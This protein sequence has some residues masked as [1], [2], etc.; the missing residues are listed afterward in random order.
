MKADSAQ[1]V[2]PCQLFRPSSQRVE[3]K[4]FSWYSR[5]LSEVVCLEHGSDS[6]Q[7]KSSI[8]YVVKKSR[9]DFSEKT[10]LQVAKRAGWLCSCPTCRA[11]TVGAT[12]DGR[13]E[14]NIGTAAH[15]CAA[16]SGG[17]RYDANM[18][19]EERGSANNG[20]WLCRDHGKA[21]DS[22]VNEFTTER[23]RE[24][25]RQAEEDSWRRVLWNQTLP[26]PPAAQKGGLNERFRRAVE[27]DLAV[28]R[29][30]TKWPRTS[31][32]LT[33]KV[34]GY[35][36]TATTKG[37][38]RA[39]GALDDLILVAPPGMGKTTTIFQIAEGVL[40]SE[41]GMPVVVPLGD[42]ATQ[43]I[44]I[45]ESI[46]KRPAF[47]DLSEADFRAIAAEPGVV[48]LLDGWNEL[49]ATARERARVQMETLKAELPELGLV[50]STRKQV[51]DVPFPGKLV[52]LMPL[53][54]E[55]QMEIAKA[56]RGE[57]G[58]K[59]VD[60]AWRTP[61]I[62]EL[63]T[64]PLYLTALLTLSDGAPFPTTKEEVL[65]RFVEAHEKDA[66]RAEVLNAEV[67]G[68]QQDFL[69]GL[70]TFATQTANTSITD[71]NARHSITE[72][73]RLLFANGQI[74]TKP[75]PNTVLETLVNSHVL[76][77]AGDTPGVSFQHQQFQEWYASHMVERRM[78]TD[79]FDTALREK[80]KAEIFNLPAWEE[81]ILFAVER[82]A[83]G[84]AP[85]KT[86][87]EKAILAAF[88]VDPMLAAE[89]I[90]HATDDVW[91]SIAMTIQKRLN[92]WH[93]PGKSDRALRFMM[94]SGRPEFFDR[95]WPLI[96]HENQQISLKALR[97]CRRFRPSLLGPEAAMR[98]KALP[99]RPRIVLLHEIASRSGMD[100]LDLATAIAK[101]D[102]NPEVQA[103]V[104]DALAFR[105][106]DRHVEAVL[107]T[108]KA[109]TFDLVVQKNLIEGVSD[110]SVK[111]GLDDA[112]ERQAKNGVS[113][114]D[115]LHAVV[116]GKGGADLSA[117]LTAII[118]EIEEVKRG[119]EQLIYEVRNRYP[120]AV[121]EGVL[122]RVRAGRT[123]FYGADDILA[124]AGFSLEE[125]ALVQLALAETPR[126]DDRA[127][128]AAS[129]LGSKAAGRILDTLADVATRL[130]KADGKYDRAVS[131]RY[132][133]LKARVA[134][135]PGA[136]LITAIQARSAQADN[137]QMA[138]LAEL[139]SRHPNDETDRCR[140]FDAEALVAIRALIEDWGNRMLAS[141]NAKRSELLSIATLASCAP[142]VS[143]LPL[144]KRL[145]DDNLRRYRAFREEAAAAGW[146][147]GNAVNEATWP[148]THEYK[149]AFLAIDA[150]ETASLMRE[151]LADPHFGELAAGVLA[152]QWKAAN[153]PP[154]NKRLLGGV[155]FSRVR[156][157]R[158]AVAANPTATS[159]EAEAMFAAIE[160]LIADGATDDQKK[161]AAALG[162]VAVRLPHGQR[163]AM[164]E[165]L[166]ALTPRRGRAT[167][168]LNLIL[169]GA[170]I[171]S[172]L[173]A[174]GI[175]ETFEAAKKEPWIL[176]QSDGYE[177]RDWLRLLPFTNR[178]ANALKIVHGMPDA[179]RE[180]RF[181]EG[182][183][184]GFVETPSEAAEDVLFKLG[185][186]DPR[187]Y[188]NY[189]WRDAALKLGTM[190]AACRLVDLTA[191]GAFVGQSF[192]GRLWSR[193]LGT[194][195]AEFPEV[196]WHVY[197]LLK[198]GVASQ[199]L[200]LLA[201]A[202][203]ES[204]DSEGLLLLV[205]IENKQERS[206]LGWR[207][208]EN[209]VTEHVPVENWSG[210][211]NVVPVPAPELRQ[212]LFAMMTDGGLTDAA[213]RCLNA[214]GAIRD[215]YGVP[216]S[217]PRHPDL[218]S[219]KSWPIMT[220]D[221]DATVYG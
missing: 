206:L 63:V 114:Y 110:E 203:A 149:R 113:A 82:T 135:I 119:E 94:N 212:K 185:E 25:K 50:V 128:A 181:L 34:E 186:E 188:Q 11:L 198:G 163:E 180:P 3:D 124:S 173:V 64:I 26:E 77:R 152:S 9:D 162:I 121:A 170:E 36:E 136:S 148:M 29:N 86:A 53:N 166:V 189:G 39:V 200:E 221:P 138:R 107:R 133:L 59:I 150:P 60:Q 5:L 102:H 145:L 99:P 140:P 125:E 187:F 191:N 165:K 108:A 216:L 158:A 48:L 117:E 24:W 51:L 72:T 58:A 139:L 76:M 164:I 87:C 204:P 27:A 93:L 127:E 81:A 67:K 141:G 6:H 115:R 205:D 43:D 161:L 183:V 144:L 7:K 32:A 91:A 74:T 192:D 199:P 184:R 46:L 195:I 47:R 129:V 131:D 12:A 197:G 168:L 10:K 201:H 142:D 78:M 89:M 190:S 22:D 219:R 84:G 137:E 83:R 178:P 95:I 13:S 2:C 109:E 154:P 175:A 220:L 14:I 210:A 194:L 151:Y 21:V 112:R 44:P 4:L 28:F 182:M 8:R 213:A 218:A 105:R 49:N 35:G 85:G 38:A 54:D 45:L 111:N 202:I 18:T 157:K 134:H 160:P 123:L 90:Y 73:G 40:A 116:Y 62:R 208:I 207:T 167:L 92:R 118:G 31:V 80:L 156:E 172:K 88:E 122:A 37:L 159:A 169:S 132:H 61:G 55:Q 1:R 209:V 103:S 17:P 56:V 57:A 100:G 23:L 174:D 155:D 143:L 217:E 42:W 196:R 65:R 15:I 179:Q 176:T 19:A 20:I 215:E 30:T 98:I 153:E 211:Y 214:I 146:R 193:Q 70:A 177:L 106:A 69:D 126:G 104:V 66:R 147:Q 130:R 97:N 101:E 71:S 68:F 120:R 171:D 33:L 16:A 52:E 75:E 96:T 41:S 79:I